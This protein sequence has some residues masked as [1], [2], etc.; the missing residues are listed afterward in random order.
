MKGTLAMRH[1]RILLS[2]CCVLVATGCATVVDGDRQAIA[3][4]TRSAGQVLAGAQCLLSNEHETLRVTTPTT[5][6]VHH[7]YADLKLQCTKPGYGPREQ[8]VRSDVKPT[9]LGNVLI[10]GAVGM[11]LDHLSGSAYRYPS[12]IVV[13]MGEMLPGAQAAAT[14]PARPAHT[15][16]SLMQVALA[17][18]ESRTV[19]LVRGTACDP[20]DRPVLLQQDAAT[21]RFITQ[22]RD[23]RIART[24]CRRSECRFVAH[25]D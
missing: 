10:G 8:F 4:E 18:D 15:M 11:G 20:A 7:G 12:S 14:P 9:V 22:C 6:S 2:G 5:V 16:Q 24:V 25:D 21:T 19:E 13:D 17:G 3:L 23:G 1:L